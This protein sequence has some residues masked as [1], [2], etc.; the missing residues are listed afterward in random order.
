MPQKF[1]AFMDGIDF[2]E[3]RGQPR[4]G[5]SLYATAEAVLKHRKCAEECGVV[6]VEV[7]MTRWVHPQNLKHHT[8]EE[9]A[10]A[11]ADRRAALEGEVGAIVDELWGKPKE[12]SVQILSDWIAER[13]GE[14]K[15]G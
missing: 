12:Q 6:E 8:R 9:V 11:K 7:S 14:E 2:H 1:T 15:Q 4:G 3:E 13:R 10:Q 5:N